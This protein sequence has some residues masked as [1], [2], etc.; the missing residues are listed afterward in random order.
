MKISDV[1]DSTAIKEIVNFLLNASDDEVFTVRELS[2]KFDVAHSTIK[3]SR[4]LSN[5][6]MKFEGRNYFGSPKAIQKLGDI[7]EGTHED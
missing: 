5:Y 2:D 6:R 1:K 3:G 7:L 4:V